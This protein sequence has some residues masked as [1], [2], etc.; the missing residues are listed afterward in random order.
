MTNHTADLT[1]DIIVA[2]VIAF[3]TIVAVHLSPLHGFFWSAGTAIVAWTL[4]NRL[5]DWLLA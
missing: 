3:L 1:G 4:L 2:L 5:A